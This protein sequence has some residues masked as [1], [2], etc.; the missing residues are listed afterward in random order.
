MKSGSGLCVRPCRC[1]TTL[2]ISN[3]SGASLP[4]T[5][6]AIRVLTLMNSS[7]K[8]DGGVVRRSQLEIAGKFHFHSAILATQDPAIVPFTEH[9]PVLLIVP[10]LIGLIERSKI[11]EPHSKTL[12]CA[13]AKAGEPPTLGVDAIV[14]FCSPLSQRECV[15]ARWKGE[16]V[17]L[18]FM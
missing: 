14:F 17:V 8:K 10:V 9:P 4:F 1:G 12:T 15:A 7:H 2:S 13:S 11:S 16:G 5:R 6:V 18:K 3:D